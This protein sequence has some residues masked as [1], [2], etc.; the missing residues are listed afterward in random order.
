M[1][2]VKFG[3]NGRDAETW[4][5]HRAATATSGVAIPRRSLTSMNALFVF[6]FATYGVTQTILHNFHY[7]TLPMRN[8]LGLSAL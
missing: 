1:D 3:L 2:D 8:S 5:P 6:G 7:V 4:R